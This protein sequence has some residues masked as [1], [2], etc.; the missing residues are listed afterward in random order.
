MKK[1]IRLTESDLARIVKRVIKENA[2]LTEGVPNTAVLA[3]AGPITGLE[4]RG[5]CKGADYVK[6]SIKIKNTGTDAYILNRPSLKVPGASGMV[7]VLDFNVTVNGKPSWSNPENQN[8]SFIP[9]GQTGLLNLV[10]GVDVRNIYSNY[11]FATDRAAEDFPNNTKKRELAIQTAYEKQKQ[12]IV[13]FQNAKSGTLVITYNG[14][15]PLEIPVNLGGFK[16]ETN[17]NCDAPI[18]LPKGF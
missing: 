3:A 10:V 5:V 13:N 9:K 4:A 15:A 17:R 6:V 8:Q 2:L 14:A 18:T 7:R 11:K 12:E 1:I 16:I